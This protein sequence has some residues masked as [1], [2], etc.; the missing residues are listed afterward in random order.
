VPVAYMVLL[1]RVTT[2]RKPRG[3]P[4][5]APAK[6]LLERGPKPPRLRLEGGKNQSCTKH[7]PNIRVGLPV[8]RTVVPSAEP[9]IVYTVSYN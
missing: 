6:A 2:G 3:S 4:G 5:V 1:V 7:I 8:Y 9:V